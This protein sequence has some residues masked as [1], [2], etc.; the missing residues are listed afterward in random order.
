MIQ[1]TKELAENLIDDVN[2]LLEECK[3][4]KG[5]DRYDRRI[6][7]YEKEIAELKEAISRAGSEERVAQVKR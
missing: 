6:A 4:F 7:V 3:L 1:I 2:E 5:Y